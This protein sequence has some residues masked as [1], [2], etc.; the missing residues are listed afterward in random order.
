LME[1]LWLGIE[2]AVERQGHITNHAMI[3]C[4]N[5]FMFTDSSNYKAKVS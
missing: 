5:D 4:I 1:I 3:G 2:K